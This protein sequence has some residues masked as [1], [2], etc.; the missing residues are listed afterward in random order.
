M[1]PKKKFALLTVLATVVVL[2]ACTSGQPQ[3]AIT[4]TVTPEPPVAEQSPTVAPAPKAVAEETWT[5]F[6]S[7][8]LIEFSVSNVDCSYS[9]GSMEMLVT[10]KNISDR[11]MI[12]IEASATVN[13]VFDEQMTGV[14]I[15]SDKSLA[16]GDSVNVGSWGSSCFP[17][18]DISGDDRRLLEMDNLEKKTKVKISV[19]KIAFDDGEIVEF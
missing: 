18:S 1:K 3:P 13:D 15:S 14:N 11:E 16:A 9:D 7:H 17:L 8:E 10:F 12:A 5:D 6:L 2:T 19:T 4:V